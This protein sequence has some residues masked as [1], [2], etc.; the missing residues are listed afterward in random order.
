MLCAFATVLALSLPVEAR[1]GGGSGAPDDPYLIYTAEHMNEIGVRRDDWNKEFLLMADIDLSEYSE[2]N[3]NIIGYY[4][5][6][7]YT[8]KP[9]SGVFEGN[10]HTIYGFTYHS[11]QTIGSVGLF[12][13]ISDAYIREVRLVTPDVN[14][15]TA[16]VGA[17]VG[18]CRHSGVRDCYI[19]GG[20]VTGSG[21]VGG[22]IGEA[23]TLSRIERCRSSAQVCGVA[24]GNVGG[25]IGASDSHVLHCRAVGDVSGGNR[26]GG[27]IGLDDGLIY[28]C[29]S[30]GTVRGSAEVGGLVGRQDYGYT[31]ASYSSAFVIGDTRVGALVGMDYRGDSKFYQ[32][33]FWDVTVNPALTGIGNR[34]DPDLVLGRTTAELQAEATYSGWDFAYRRLDGAGDIWSFPPGGGLSDPDVRTR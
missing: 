26:V 27:L 30:G 20:S 4:E 24:G 16:Q 17:L 2:S 23:D 7:Y 22:L 21:L 6:N 34:D 15:P 3:F 32:G 18:R 12:A 14:A 19:D 9:F 11:E 29:Y 28:E 25:L 31:T 1:Y 5:N 13:Y 10:N 33:C 8:D